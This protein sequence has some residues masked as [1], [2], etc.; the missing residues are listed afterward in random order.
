MQ[1]FVAG[2]AHLQLEVAEA[3]LFGDDAVGL[4]H[5]LADLAHGLVEA[6]AGLDA[7]DHQV[8]HVG[9]AEEDLLLAVLADEP[10][11]DSGR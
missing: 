6:E 2:A 1:H 8:E 11:D 10:E 5:L 9:Q 4:L 7:D 3:E